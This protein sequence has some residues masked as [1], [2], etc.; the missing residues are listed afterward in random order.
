VGGF[1]K[2]K[3]ILPR[4]A[5]Q[6]GKPTRIESNSKRGATAHHRPL[7]LPKAR[8]SIRTPRRTPRYE[9]IQRGRTGEK[10]RQ[11]SKEKRRRTSIGDTG[12]KKPTFKLK[13]HPRRGDKAIAFLE[14]KPATRCRKTAGGNRYKKCQPSTV[15][16]SAPKKRI[17]E[18]NQLKQEKKKPSAVLVQEYTSVLKREGQK[19]TTKKACRQ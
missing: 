6:T 9:D 15:H 5:L 17:M 4:G 1:K 10:R 13:H 19:P 12:R 16:K 18:R 14:R 7:F 11:Y 8:K 2:V 3:A